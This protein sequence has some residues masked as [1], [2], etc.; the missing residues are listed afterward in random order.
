MYQYRHLLFILTWKEI[1]IR[2]KQTV[3]GFLWAIFMPMLIVFA[4]V[5]VRIAFSTVSGRA[6]VLADL[7]SVC[8]KSVPW[9]FFVSSIRFSTNSL[10]GN[11]ELVTKVYFP[12]E[13]FPLSCLLAALFDFAIASALLVVLL[14]LAR[15]GVSIHLVWVPVLLLLLIVLTAGLGMFLACA[16]L[17][18]R[19]V[20]YIVE[21]LLTFGIFFTPVFYEARSLGKWAPWLMLNPVAPIFEAINNV[22]VRHRPPELFWLSVSACW[23]LLGFLVSRMIFDKAEPAFAENI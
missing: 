18:F 14:A 1:K 21:V 6:L 15:I 12:R 5:L 23:S 20:K 8:V 17:F 13:V 10:I 22:V 9:A 11:S 2:Y 4:G 19:D 7:A 3:M 16:N